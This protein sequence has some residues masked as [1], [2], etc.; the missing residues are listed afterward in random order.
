M[1]YLN[2][3]F[4]EIDITHLVIKVHQELSSVKADRLQNYYYTPVH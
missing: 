3:S 4:S 2:S 1:S